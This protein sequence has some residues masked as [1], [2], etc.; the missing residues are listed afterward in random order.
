GILAVFLVCGCIIALAVTKVSPRIAHE[1]ESFERGS[2]RYAT[3]I[4]TRLRAQEQALLGD[5]P[6]LKDAHLSEPALAWISQSGDRLLRMAPDLASQLVICLFLVPFL[7]FILLKDAHE[8]RRALLKLVPNRYFETVYGLTS[9]ILD[10]MGGYVA[11]R[12]IEAVL[13]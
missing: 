9:R 4:A 10:E 5:N 8:I 7:T 2:S 3:D 11:A 12:I 13:V 6:V 1:V